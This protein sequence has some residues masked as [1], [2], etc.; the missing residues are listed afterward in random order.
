[1]SDILRHIY[2]ACDPFKPATEEYYLDCGAVRGGTVL[3]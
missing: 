3:T 2:N 1:M